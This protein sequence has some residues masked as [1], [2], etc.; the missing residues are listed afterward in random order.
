MP[1]PFAADLRRDVVAAAGPDTVTFLQGQLSQEIADLVIGESRWSLLLQPQGKVDAWLRVHRAGEEE[2]RLD[3]DEGF[4]DAVVARL[5]RFKLRTRCDLS[6]DAGVA[7]LALRHG[8]VDGALP[9]GWPDVAGGDLPGRALHDRQGLELPEGTVEF[10]GQQFEAERIRAG[11][12]R[13]GAEITGDTIPAELGQWLVEGSVSFTKGCFTGQEL[14][15]RIDSRG[16]KVPRHLRVFTADRPPP[17]PGLAVIVGD[18]SV[19]TVTSSAVRA[20]GDVVGLA[21][22]HRSVVPPADA[23]TGDT[24]I[25]FPGEL[26]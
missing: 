7:M 26:V 13:M 24:P 16:G 25:H 1:Q 5:A 8:T 10:D 17:E 12:P 9:C 11:V 14:V 22:L 20:R 15:A 3:V 2:V 4:G 19:G 23:T 18:R 6:L 21:F